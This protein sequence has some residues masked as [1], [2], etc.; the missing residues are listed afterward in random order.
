MLPNWFKAMDSTS[1]AKSLQSPSQGLRTG[2]VIQSMGRGGSDGWS[3]V[4]DGRIHLTHFFATS[5]IGS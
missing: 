3:T 5:S 1:R 2:K 4:R